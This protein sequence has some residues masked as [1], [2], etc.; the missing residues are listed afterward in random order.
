MF[1][2]ITVTLIAVSVAE[3]GGQADRPEG[4]PRRRDVQ[5]RQRR[6]AP[7]KVDGDRAV[8]SQRYPAAP[9]DE[10]MS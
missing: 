4:F 10:G 8:M 2:A 6:R 9:T 5:S 7:P 3:A 1:T